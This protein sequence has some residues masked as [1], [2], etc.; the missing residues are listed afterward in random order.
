[1]KLNKISAQSDRG[2]QW[3][4]NETLEDLDHVNDR[5]VLSHNAKDMQEKVDTLQQKPRKWVSL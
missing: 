5:C 1:M 3:D 2:I 4:F